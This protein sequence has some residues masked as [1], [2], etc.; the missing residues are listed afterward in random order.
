MSSLALRTRPWENSARWPLQGRQYTR[1]RT[2]MG[3]REAQNSFPILLLTNRC[4]RGHSLAR[5]KFNPILH[6][7]DQASLSK[8]WFWA[9]YFRVAQPGKRQWNWKLLSSVTSGL[10]ADAVKRERGWAEVMESPRARNQVTGKEPVVRLP[11]RVFETLARRSQ[12]ELSFLEEGREGRRGKK[13]N[14]DLVPLRPSPT[15]WLFSLGVYIN[16]DT[17]LQK[18]R[19]N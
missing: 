19:L 10:R 4:C 14:T 5:T 6:L 2:R 13:E 9:N 8:N 15:T 18:W 17:G 7:S 1:E 12:C 11:K 3:S 16:R